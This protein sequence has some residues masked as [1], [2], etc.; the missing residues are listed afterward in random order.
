M[1]TSRP[2]CF[3][4]SV[5]VEP[6]RAPTKN[7]RSACITTSRVAATPPLVPT[8]PA[9]KRMRVGKRPLAADGGAHRGVQHRG[10]RLERLAGAGEDH[11]AAADDDGAFRRDE[12]V[13]GLLDVGRMR[14]RAH[15]GIAVVARLRPHVGGVDLVLLHVVGQADVRRARPAR[16][17]RAERAAHRAGDL[18]GAVDGGVPL[19]ERA[20]ERL[21]VEFGERELAARAD[22]D[23]RGDAQHGD[24]GLVRPPRGR[25][26]D[27]WRRR[28][29]A[30]RR[31]R[32]CP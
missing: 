2:G 32:A 16:G 31:R 17:H 6:A 7:T 12:L 24:R 5:V 19:G 14:A 9:H 8:T 15:R 23:V 26:G 13:G 27:R 11:A 29:W 3:Q 20:V 28:R 18:V 1:G 25:G 22:R 30:L 4:C 21:L 10:E